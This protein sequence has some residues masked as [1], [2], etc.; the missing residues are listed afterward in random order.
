MKT[1]RK[2]KRKKKTVKEFSKIW[3]TI[4]LVVTLFDLNVLII[5]DRMETLAVTMVTE[6]AAVFGGYMIKAYLGK[7]NEEALKHEDSCIEEDKEP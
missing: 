6:V 3:V 1:L 2:K 4:I 7:K 5:L